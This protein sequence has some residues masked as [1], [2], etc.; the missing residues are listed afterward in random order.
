M[1]AALL[2]AAQVA[3]PPPAAAAPPADWS[4]LPLVP[5]RMAPRFDPLMSNYVADLVRTGRCTPPRP[6][7]TS[8]TM[9]VA[10]LVTA[11]GRVRTIVPR[12]IGCPLAEQYTSG[13]MSRMARGNILRTDGITDAWYRAAITYSWGA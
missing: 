12:A 10:M 4:Q 13:L 1:I 7:A 8:W 6:G 5:W 9:D 2:L 11:D 3:V